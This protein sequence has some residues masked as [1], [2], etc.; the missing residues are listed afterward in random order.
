[1]RARVVLLQT[2]VAM[3]LEMRHSFGP[4]NLVDITLCSHTISLSMADVSEN[5]RTHES[6]EANSVPKDGPPPVVLQDLVFLQTLGLVS[7]I[8]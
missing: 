5:H 1:M 4:Q 6:V 8:P 7:S 2:K 3:Q